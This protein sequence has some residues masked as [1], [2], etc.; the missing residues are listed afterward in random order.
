[1]HAYRTHHCGELR[2]SNEGETIKLSGWINRKR[3]HG[4]VLFI[5]LRDTYGVTQ[6]VV[7][8]GSPLLAQAEGWRNES[9]AFVTTSRHQYV[10]V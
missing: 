8:E 1:M 10:V 2:K 4:G 6:C 5:D 9:S 3:D 7:D